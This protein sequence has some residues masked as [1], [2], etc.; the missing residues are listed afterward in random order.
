MDAILCSVRDMLIVC[1]F[2]QQLRVTHA[3]SNQ[4][5]TSRSTL[6]IPHVMRNHSLEGFSEAFTR[7]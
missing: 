4:P 5:I 2:H 3:S 7:L 1:R 6:Y